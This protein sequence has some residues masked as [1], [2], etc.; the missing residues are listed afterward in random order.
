MVRDEA[1]VGL[2]SGRIP[3]RVSVGDGDAP[4]RGC[5]CP[6]LSGNLAAFNCQKS[7]VLYEFGSTRPGLEGL[8]APRT[9]D[10]KTSVRSGKA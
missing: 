8:Y 5:L 7:S 6:I 3:P 2:G 4:A 1:R 9:N 10:K